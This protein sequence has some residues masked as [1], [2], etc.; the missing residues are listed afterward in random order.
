MDCKCKGTMVKSG[1]PYYLS[2][3]YYQKYVC[4]ECQKTKVKV[5]EGY[6]SKE[7]IKV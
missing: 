2:N 3:N 5:L 7:R 4:P 1:S 6:S